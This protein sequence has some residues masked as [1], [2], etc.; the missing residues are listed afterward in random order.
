[1]KQTIELGKNGYLS[2]YD[3]FKGEN[4]KIL[5]SFLSDTFINFAKFAMKYLRTEDCDLYPFL[6][7]EM[8]LNS[9]FLPS[10][11]KASDKSIVLLEF[12]ID[13][14]KNSGTRRMENEYSSGRVDFYVRHKNRDILIEHKFAWIS[15]K[16]L[17]SNNPIKKDLLKKLITASNQ[18]KEI[19]WDN[20]IKI[21][22]LTA[23]VYIT[24]TVQSEKEFKEV[25][26]KLSFDNLN[27]VYN[28]V[29]DDYYQKLNE[30]TRK[31]LGETTQT[32]LVSWNIP[33]FKNYYCCW[34]NN[35]KERCEAYPAIF[36]IGTVLK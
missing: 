22:L 35:E 4:S 21:A 18:I 28:K 12:P 29:Y 11:M 13:R 19:K 27:K 23:P 10:L 36:F 7:N 8:V 32:F 33:N 2:I 5:R 3:E 17:N 14:S 9:I 34:E 24:E 30:A 1:M 31:T 20:C 6:Y 16:S 26:K 25:I 15:Y